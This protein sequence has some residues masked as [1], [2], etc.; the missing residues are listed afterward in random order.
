MIAGLDE[1]GRGPL[2]GPLV[3]AG[4]TVTTDGPLK[5]IGV[6]DSKQLT[7]QRREELTAQIQRLASQIEY[8]IIPAAD[9]DR[10]RQ[11]KTL[12]EIE[13]DAFA[14]IIDR[15]RP[16]TCYVDA[17]D[18]LEDR[19]GADIKKALTCTPTI[20]SKHK[21][22][23]LYPV[24]SAASIL[25]KVTR[26]YHVRLLEQELQEHLNLPLGSGYQTDLLTMDFL[27]AWLK[28]FDTLPPCVRHS[29]ESSRRLM[30]HHKTKKL[31]EF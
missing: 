18:V 25:A 21:G 6:R 10:L 12:N 3:I 24:C 22:D 19:F 1:A 7:P 15:L 28:K 13:V 4:L 11:H 8:V 16:D 14:Q 26:D 2:L 20:I 31:D 23:S 5:K 29:W 9:I 17:A 27:R 30:Q